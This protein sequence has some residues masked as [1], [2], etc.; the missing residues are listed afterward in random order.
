MFTAGSFADALVGVTDGGAELQ[1]VTM[2]RLNSDISKQNL[3]ICFCI[4]SSLLGD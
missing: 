2:N 3:G 4:Q 1:A